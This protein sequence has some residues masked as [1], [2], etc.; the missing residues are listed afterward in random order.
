VIASRLRYVKM[1]GILM[2]GGELTTRLCRDRFG[3]SHATAKRDLQLFR[4]LLPVR[5]SNSGP[6]TVLRWEKP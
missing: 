1:A 3:V 6:G 4:I 2:R 5:A